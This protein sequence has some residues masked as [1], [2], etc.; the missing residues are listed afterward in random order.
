MGQWFE[1]RWLTCGGPQ[2]RL[3]MYI[4]SGASGLSAQ[5]PLMSVASDFLPHTLPRVL[6]KVLSPLQALGRVC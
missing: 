6:G 1:G 5:A 4:V 2:A 3:T